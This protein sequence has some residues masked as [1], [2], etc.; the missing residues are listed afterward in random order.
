MSKED[1]PMMS[2]ALT[3]AAAILTALL[4]LPAA[5]E[6][7]HPI[8]PMMITI[9]TVPTAKLRYATAGD[10]QFKSDGSLHITV[11]QMSDRRY[12]FLVAV[13][14]LVEALLCK[15]AGVSQAAVD[16]FDKAYETKRPPTDKDSEP[17][18]A[19]GAPYRREHVIASVTERLAAELLN[20]DWSR[21]SAEV[22]SK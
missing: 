18:N 6:Q 20:V 16:A 13:H 22:A 10:W 11:T 12:E 4:T 19:A 5:S 15:Q 3:I 8:K 17:G 9:E 21:Y 14:E 2:R 1:M 7:R